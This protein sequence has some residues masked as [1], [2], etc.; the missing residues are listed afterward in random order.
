M[1]N[2][3]NHIFHHNNMSNMNTNSTSMSVSIQQA[4][5][6]NNAGTRFVRQCHYDSAV[7]S[8]TAVLKILKPLAELVEGNKSATE[9]G[10]D[11]DTT[12]N[13]QESTASDVDS[14]TAVPMTIS[15]QNKSMD[16]KNTND[17]DTT[18]TAPSRKLRHFVFRDPIVIDDPSSQYSPESLSKF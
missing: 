12:T 4:I 7:K 3:R 1:G 16:T 15:F 2:N 8:F 18:T 14:S 13:A 10:N 17:N 5:L 11:N 6:E 9:G